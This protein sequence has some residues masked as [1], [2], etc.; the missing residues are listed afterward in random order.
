MDWIRSLFGQ[1]ASIAAVEKL[2]VTARAR[3][4]RDLRYIQAELD[5]SNCE[6]LRRE[7][8]IGEAMRHNDTHTAKQIIK[9]M[10]QILTCITAY[11]AE[12]AQLRNAMIATGK[13]MRLIKKHARAIDDV[14]LNQRILTVGPSTNQILRATTQHEQ[15]AEGMAEREDLL[16]DHTA[17]ITEMANRQESALDADPHPYSE[18]KLFEQYADRFAPQQHSTPPTFPQPP[19]PPSVSL[20]EQQHIR[21][22]TRAPQRTHDQALV[23][24]LPSPPYT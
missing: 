18:D 4:Q 5:L 6:K 19:P 7:A 14:K 12:I 8:A 11:E 22:A 24:S 13:N 23:E 2:H 20:R 1:S 21:P 3:H 15:F 10:P 17:A 9:E 16:E